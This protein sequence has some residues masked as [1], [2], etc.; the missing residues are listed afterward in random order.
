MAIQTALRREA[1]T[2]RSGALVVRPQPTT[3]Q[4][5]GV[6][7]GAATML[8]TVVIDGGAAGGG[9]I[10]TAEAVA[11]AASAV[12]LPPPDSCADPTTQPLRGNKS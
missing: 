11:W 6:C 8:S 5:D 1:L 2:S 12:Q 9:G 10:R 3:S 4:E 7:G